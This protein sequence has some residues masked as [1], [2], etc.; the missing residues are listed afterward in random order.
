MSY[1]ALDLGHVLLSIF[2]VAILRIDAPEE[3]PPLFGSPLEAYSV[4]RFWAKFWHRLSAPCCASLGRLVSRR[5]AGM[6]PG[7]RLEKLFIIFWIFLL[8]AV[9]HA[10]ADWQAEEPCTP[11]CDLY[12]YL[13]HFAAGAIETF[14]PPMVERALKWTNNGRVR[15]LLWSESGRRYIGYAWFLGVFVWS[16]PKWQYQKFHF[17]LQQVEYSQNWDL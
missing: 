3:W 7:S 11:A 15:Q 2:F 4:R 13:A 10:V 14:V 17:T 5:V 9:Y 6:R 12:F 1:L 8:S 16:V